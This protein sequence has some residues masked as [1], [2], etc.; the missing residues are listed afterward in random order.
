MPRGHW[1]AG[2]ARID[3][4]AARNNNLNCGDTTQV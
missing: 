4:P 3:R 2:Q 1:M